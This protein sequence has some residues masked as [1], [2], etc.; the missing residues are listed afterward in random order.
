MRAVAYAAFGADPEVVE[1]PDPEPSPDGVVLRVDATGLCRSDWHGW[2]GHDSAIT[3]FP[4]VPGH[5]LAGTVVAVGARVTRWRGG[6]RV[7]VPFVCA[8]GTCRQCA[9]GAQQV[10]DH[11]RQPG[12]TDHGSWAERVRIEHADVNLVPVP[13]ELASE[14]VA[15][16]GC[17]FATAYRA[18]LQVGALRAGE[19][20]AIHGCGGLGLSAVML[21]VAAG[22]HVIA[23]DASAGARELALGLGAASAHDVGVDLIALTDGGVDLGLDTAGAEAACVASVLGLRTQGRHVQVGLLPERPRVPMDVVIAREL[24]LRGSHG[25]AAHAYPELL[26]L[27]AAGRLRP[28]ELVT[29]RIGLAEAP[30]ALRAMDGPGTPGMTMVDPSR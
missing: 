10:C 28:E 24:V 22:A 13:D 9:R 20:V 17:R 23:V 21:A 19:T 11:Q 14:A 25:M 7:A 5:E 1:L 4:H 26:A 18:V 8:C 30:A 16:L 27:L 15:A 6:E 2:R 3:A 29:R 12:F